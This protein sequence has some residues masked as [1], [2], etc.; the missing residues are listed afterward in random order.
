MCIYICISV[1]IYVYANVCLYIYIY[2]CIYMHICI[3][4]HVY[5]SICVYMHMC[6]PVDF[7]DRAEFNTQ[8]KNKLMWILEHLRKYTANV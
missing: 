1:Y 6:N 5:K 7:R 2:I 4:I 8:G 3:C